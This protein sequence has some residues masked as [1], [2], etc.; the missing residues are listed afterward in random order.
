M[1]GV[2][3]QQHMP[4]LIS[5][6][7]SHRTALSAPLAK[8]P[9]RS[10]GFAATTH[11]EPPPAKSRYGKQGAP[12]RQLRRSSTPSALGATVRRSWMVPWGQTT[13][14][15]SSGG[16]QRTYVRH[17]GHSKTP[18]NVWSPLEP[19]YS[20]SP[21]SRTTSSISARASPRWP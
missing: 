13:Q 5:H 21:L 3:S 14:S 16:K 19:A 7:L 9:P 12:R 1:Q 6:L 4:L 15:T 18:C 20:R 8:R 11:Q 2:S 17:R 10:S